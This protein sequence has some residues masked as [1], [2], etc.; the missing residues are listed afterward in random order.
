MRNNMPVILIGLVLVFIITIVFEWGM[1]YLG[2]SRRSDA[3]GK[4]EGRKI[5]YQE[6]SELVR[7][8]TE[9]YKQQSKQEADENALRQIRDQVWNNLVTQALLERE[10]KKAGITVSD[11]EIIDWVRGENPPEFLVQQFRDSTGQF[12]RDSYESAL[13]DPRNREIWVKVE[14]ALREQRMA[15]KMQSIVFSSIRISQGE[16]KDRFIDQNVKANL[17]YAFFDPNKFIADSKVTVTDDDL[18]KVYNDNTE[19]FKVQASRKIKYVFF[20]DQPSAKDSQDVFDQINSVLSQAK[21]G[22]SFDELQKNYA[23]TSPKPAFFKHGELTKEKESAVFSAKVGDLVGP[24]SDGEGYHIFKILEEKKNNDAFVKASHILLSAGTPEQETAAKKLA[25]ELIARAK[26]GED[27]ASLARQYSTEPGASQSGGELGWFGKGRMVKQFE[28]AALNG[29]PGQI[30]GP[31]KTQF[32]IH[33]IK[34][35]GRD[36]R[37]VKVS[38]ISIPVKASSRTR[39]DAFQRAQD[40]AYVAKKGNFD[41]E[42]KSLGLQVQETPDFQ[43]GMMVPGLGFFESIN[44]YAFKSSVGDISEAYPVN[45]GYA[46]VKT[47]EIKKEGVKSFDEVKT[48]LQP[49]ALHTKKM[50][51]LKEL[52]QKLFAS[53]GAGGDLNSL[54]SDPNILIQTTGDFNVGGGIP[55]VGREFA[56]N[57]IAKTGEIGKILPPVEGARG[58]YLVKILNRT[59]FDSTGFNAQKNIV[60]AQLLQEKKQRILTQWLEKLK[61]TADI[62]DDREVFFR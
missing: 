34:I 23:E 36:N 9:Q 60:S 16:I 48:S 7:Q 35:E 15:E 21:S 26:K 41:T 14:K 38:T 59:S 61:E 31:V 1:D 24:V 52:A 46:I 53:L 57:G 56:L 50:L 4:I 45:N 49:R 58:Y 12:R 18:K 37:E 32:G 6:F 55:S 11:Q 27:F 33:V 28:E 30:I 47:I 42:A 62:E 54:A 3:V 13:N 8:Q 39:D 2:I 5:S 43:K 22:I 40:F 51:Q 17:Q 44:K 10:T 20:S 25:G 29:R 19:E